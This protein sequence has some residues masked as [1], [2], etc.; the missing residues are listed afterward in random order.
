MMGQRVRAPTTSEPLHPVTIAQPFYLG[1]TEVTFA[2]YDA[3]CEA[4]GRAKPSD[5]GWPERD[6]RPVINVDWNDAR[7]YAR[8]LDAMTGSG[9]R[10]PSEA[11]WE[12]AARAGTTTEYALPAPDGSDD[13][14]GKG[15]ANCSDCGS[16]WDGKQTAPVGSFEPNAWGLHDMHGNVWE[17]V[18]DCWHEDYD[19]APD[20]GRPWLSE[21]GGDCR[22]PGAARRV[23]GRQSGLRALRRPRSALPGLPQLRHRVSGVVF[24]P[25][26]RALITEC[27]ASGTDGAK[28]RLRALRTARHGSGTRGT[29]SAAPGLGPH[30]GP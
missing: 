2:Q 27:R 19:G 1:A 30:S 3:Y 16:K 11:E 20:D 17:W 5:A 10:L 26:L 14:E 4:T 24:V 7:A 25:H 21:N 6:K 12:Y 29:A 13:I 18:E 23:L 28:R 9:C 22:H 15:L 8:W